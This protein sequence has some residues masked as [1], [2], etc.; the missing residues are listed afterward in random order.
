M[1]RQFIL[2][3]ILSVRLKLKNE[4][5]LKTSKLAP[6]TLNPL[7]AWLSIFGPIC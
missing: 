3:N 2:E 6:I 7:V 4:K 5:R 1:A